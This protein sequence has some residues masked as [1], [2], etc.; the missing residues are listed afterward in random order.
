MGITSGWGRRI[1]FA[2]GVV[3]L[4]GCAT[5]QSGF[6]AFG[7]GNNNWFDK[8]PAQGSSTIALPRDPDLLADDGGLQ[9]AIHNSVELANQKR[10]SEARF[11]LA[12]V[13]ESQQPD[14]EAYKALTCAIALLSLREGRISV[15]KRT[16]RQ[17]DL[18]LKE[19]LNVPA[20]YVEVIS[21]Y[22]LMEGKPLP[23][24]TP[25]GV[26]RLKERYFPLEQAKLQ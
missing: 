2:L 25:E 20:S 15:F 19:P 3:T 11:I 7:F 5:D 21:L 26:N 4:S 1:T 22:R 12:D 17:L 16:A 14:D 6:S 8:S 10:F 18:A 9:S 24:N 13:R 23:V